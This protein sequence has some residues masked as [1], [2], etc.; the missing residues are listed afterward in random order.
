MTEKDND[1]EDY[2]II[3]EDIARVNVSFKIIVIGDSSVGKS[4]LILRVTKD[5]FKDYYTSTIV[6]NFYL[7]IYVSK[8]K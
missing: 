5:H 8:I 1:E 4:S 3:H 6:S 7:L 2:E